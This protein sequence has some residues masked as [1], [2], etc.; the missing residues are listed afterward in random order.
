MEFCHMQT[1]WLLNKKYYV[2]PFIGIVENLL[3]SLKVKVW[4]GYQKKPF[5]LISS[6]PPHLNML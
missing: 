2:T 1:G 6:G 4:L 5:L 3:Q